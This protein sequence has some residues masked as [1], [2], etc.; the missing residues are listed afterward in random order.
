MPTDYVNRLELARVL[1]A[2]KRSDDAVKTLADV[3]ADMRK[4]LL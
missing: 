3:L 4:T 1:A 2:Q